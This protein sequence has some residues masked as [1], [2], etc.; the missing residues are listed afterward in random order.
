MS[1]LTSVSMPQPRSASAIVSTRSDTP[2][3]RLAD[4]R[5]HQRVLVL[6]DARPGD[7]GCE[8]GGAADH[9]LRAQH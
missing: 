3:A 5:A 2:A 9:V 6:D 8:P 7:V 1:S 4:G